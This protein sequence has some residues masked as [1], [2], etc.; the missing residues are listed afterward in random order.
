MGLVSSQITAHLMTLPQKA[1]L[2][3]RAKGLWTYREKTLPHVHCHHQHKKTASKKGNQEC[4]AKN[5]SK[6]VKVVFFL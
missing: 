3:Y 6:K 4:F 5:S 2:Q 1:I